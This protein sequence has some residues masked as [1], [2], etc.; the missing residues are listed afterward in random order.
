MYGVPA[1]LDLSF[2]H[3]TELIQV[4]IGVYDVQFHFEPD[5]AICAGDSWEL[6]DET[7]ACVDSGLPFPRPPFQLHRLLGQRVTRIE[8]VAPTHLEL[9]FER[10]ERLRFA[11]S[12][13]RYESFTIT[14]GEGARTV[15]V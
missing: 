14:A 4:R 13:E 3:R 8:V 2:L 7:G 9:T 1:D 15:I 5:A 10:G 6:F 11:D 12:S